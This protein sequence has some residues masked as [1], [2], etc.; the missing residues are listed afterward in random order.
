MAPAEICEDLFGWPSPTVSDVV[1]ALPD[2]FV[3]VGASGDI[4]YLL[5]SFRFREYCGN[6]Q[7][8]A[9]CLP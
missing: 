8:N 9:Q 2:R 5:K 6:L 3:N 7:I 4:E 1:L